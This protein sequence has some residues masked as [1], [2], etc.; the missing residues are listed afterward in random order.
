MSSRARS[1]SAASP[2]TAPVRRSREPGQI[3]AADRGEHLPH[4]GGGQRRGGPFRPLLGAQDAAHH[5]GDHR[6]AGGPQMAGAAMVVGDGGEDQPE[7][8]A[9]ER[10]GAFGEVS[11]D[12][13]GWCRECRG[14]MRLAPGAERAPV[15][16]VDFFGDR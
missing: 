16:A 13:G 15:I 11:G 8:A 10:G 14:A 5:R 3:V 6:I 4:L 12:D 7:A 2:R 9:P 1:R